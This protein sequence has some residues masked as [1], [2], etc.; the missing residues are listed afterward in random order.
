MRMNQTLW[1]LPV[2]ATAITRGPCFNV[3]PKR[4]CEISFSIDAENG[5]ERTITLLFEGVEAFKC[6]YPAA[7]RSIGHQLFREAYANLIRLEDS[8]WLAEIGKARS[9]YH[10][11]M[12]TQPRAVQHFM[13][14]FDDDPC[15]EIICEEFRPT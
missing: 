5:G 12:P 14:C 13:I 3:L 10:A 9:E 7:I 6:T 8:P 11:G 1:K 15:Y 4:Q 2:P